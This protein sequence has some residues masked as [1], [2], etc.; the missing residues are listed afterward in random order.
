MSKK[1][2]NVEEHG[3][4]IWVKAHLT[5]FWQDGLRHPVFYLLD[6]NGEPDYDRE[7]FTPKH[8]GKLNVVDE[9]LK[10]HDELVDTDVID[11]LRRRIHENQQT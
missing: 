2:H 1:P 9:R 10:R 6:E 3:E 5:Y 7:G 8:D 4:S 11:K